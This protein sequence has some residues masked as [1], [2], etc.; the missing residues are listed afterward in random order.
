MNPAAPVMRMTELELSEASCRVG[1]ALVGWEG[2][3]LAL[4]S[5]E[6]G[7]SSVGWA[8][9]RANRMVSVMASSAAVDSFRRILV[10]IFC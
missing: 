1:G 8:V 4:G 9:M 7:S 2:C 10:M 6:E 5:S 3:V